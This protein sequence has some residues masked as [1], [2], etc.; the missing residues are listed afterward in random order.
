M[1]ELTLTSTAFEDGGA[2]P[3]RH[4]CDGEDVSPP[5][6]WSGAPDAT[7]SLALIVDDPDAPGRTFLHWLA[8]GMGPDAAG[9]AE[10]ERPPTEGTNDF[11]TIGYG[12]PCPP[13]GHGPHRYFFR[14]YALDTTVDVPAGS[15]RDEL[16][17]AMRDHVL[18][19]A[20]LM[21]THERR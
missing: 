11:G 17:R 1:P 15:G 10:G 18:T 3:R 8:W 5:L 6:I 9:L 12:G 7:R 13:P 20:E 4:T 2:V 19:S 16:E 14:L 21:G